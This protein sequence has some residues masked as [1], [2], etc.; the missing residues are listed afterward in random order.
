MI[1]RTKAYTSSDGTVHATLEAAQRWEL[2]ALF[3]CTTTM[4]D[5]QNY[6]QKSI[7]NTIFANAETIKDVLTTIATSH[8]RARSINGAKRKPRAKAASSA[9]VDNGIAA[10]RAAV[11]SPV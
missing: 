4:D 9:Q 7:V 10:V 8:P 11:G 1:T 2:M 5:G 6:S 3:A